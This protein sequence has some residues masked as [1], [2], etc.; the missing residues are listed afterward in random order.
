MRLPDNIKD[1][2]ML[3]D[4]NLKFCQYGCMFSPSSFDWLHQHRYKSR[5]RSNEVCSFARECVK[6][7]EISEGGEGKS[8]AQ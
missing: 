6:P 3:S 2:C 5:V 4:Q 1:L 7:I 8:E